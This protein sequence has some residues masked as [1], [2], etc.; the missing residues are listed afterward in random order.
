L[1]TGKLLSV[2]R[3]TRTVA[4]SGWTV[5]TDEISLITD[6]GEVRSGG[7][8]CVDERSHRRERLTGRSGALLGVDRFFP[9][10]R[11]PPHDDLNDGHGRTKFV[12]KLHQ[13][14][15]DLEDD[16]PHR[17]ASKAEKRPLLQGWAIV[18]NTVGEDWDSVELSLVAGAPH[19]FIQQLS[20]P[21]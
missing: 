6:S 9:R 16:L 4:G 19:S 12:R 21:F 13:R 20:E 14:S 5:E 1:L 11:C 15:A 7:S 18:D 8:Q 10:P 3:K 17:A 2:E